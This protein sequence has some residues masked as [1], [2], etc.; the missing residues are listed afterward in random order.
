MVPLYVY[1]KMS[2]KHIIKMLM[3]SAVNNKGV[4]DWC[5]FGRFENEKNPKISSS[6]IYQRC[7]DSCSRINSSIDYH[8]KSDPGS[9]DFCEYNTSANFTADAESC[10]TCLYEYEDLTI[11]GNVLSTVQDM[12]EK[13]PGKNYTVPANVTVYGTER[14]QLSA[15]ASSSTPTS[16]A[17][18]PSTT[19]TTTSSSGLSK[20]AIAGVVLGG[21]VAIIAVLGL[22]LLLLKRRK[23]KVKGATKDGGDAA[24][25]TLSPHYQYNAVQQ[26]ADKDRYSYM[27]EAPTYQAPVEI[28]AGRGMSEMPAA[29]TPAAHR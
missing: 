24:P 18:S 17:E 10:A 22:I 16:S 8:I 29:S 25:T 23:N 21:L 5:L 13:K 3:H 9:F 2:P 11:L 20:G 12:C 7:S 28:G 1:I 4:V 26:Q 15:T 27:A 14:I 6:S 19:T